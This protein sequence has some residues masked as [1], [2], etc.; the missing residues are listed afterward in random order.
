M[1]ITLLP[2]TIDER[3]QASPGQR[4]SCYV[5]DDR[6]AIDA[7]SIALALTD[8]QT[9]TVRDV[10]VTHP[11]AD[12]IATLPIYVDDLFGTLKEPVRLHGTEEVLAILERDVFNGSV[13]PP[14]H[15]FDNG[16]T[17]VMEFV[18]F[19][20][21]ED[22][23]VAHLTFKAVTVNHIVPTVGLVFGD[24]QATIAFTSDTAA[25]EDF[26]QLANSMPKLDA[27]LIESSFPNSMSKLAE[28]SGHLTPETMGSELRKLRHEGAQVLVVHIKPTYREQII[29]E[30][31]G[32]RIPGLSAMECGREY[33]W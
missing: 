8:G 13:Y 2:S 33:N 3:G 6:V 12:H 30:L 31:D 27:I 16:R 32:L 1:K 21:N 9:E 26:W 23:R 10:V 7:G 28:V 5:V 4:L 19:R 29:K 20:T 25:T 18:P 15:K 17:R 14:F 24:G 11:H 22:F